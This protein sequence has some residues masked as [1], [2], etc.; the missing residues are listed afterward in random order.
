MGRSAAL[1][2]PGKESNTGN[3]RQPNKHSVGICDHVYW[4]AYNILRSYA[5]AWSLNEAINFR[6]RKLLFDKNIHLRKMTPAEYHLD[7]RWETI[8][9]GVKWDDGP[10][11]II[12][13]PRR[14]SVLQ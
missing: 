1:C 14:S 6:H 2:F 5:A 12:E 11:E 3:Q 9:L 8:M 7:P 4:N 13:G 10:V